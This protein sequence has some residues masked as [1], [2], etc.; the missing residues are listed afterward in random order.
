MIKALKEN[1]FFKEEEFIVCMCD[2][3]LAWVNKASADVEKML[4]DDAL[5]GL[6]RVRKEANQLFQELENSD[7]KFKKGIRDLAKEEKRYIEQNKKYPLLDLLD[8][9]YTLQAAR[10]Q[11]IMIRSY[12]AFKPHSRDTK[13]EFEAKAIEVK[14]LL[15]AAKRGFK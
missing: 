4:K 7:P 2:M 15:L 6:C 11:I 5:V 8:Y 12:K 14:K 3:A 1:N 13:E 10:D 9:K